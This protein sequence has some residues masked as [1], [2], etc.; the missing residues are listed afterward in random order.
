MSRTQIWTTG[1]ALAACLVLTA[2]GDDQPDPES[3]STPSPTSSAESSDPAP[4]DTASA[5]PETASDLVGTW[6]DDAADWTAY[7]EDDGTFTWDYQGN[8]DFLTGSYTLEDGVVTFAG[9]D[10]NDLVGQVT[11]EGLVFDLGTLTRR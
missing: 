6:R 9:L 1:A 3:S 7:F 8:V 4:T 10:G 5:L 2:C 11:P